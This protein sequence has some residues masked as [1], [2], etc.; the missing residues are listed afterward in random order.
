MDTRLPAKSILKQAPTK[1]KRTVSDEQKAQ[2]ERNRRN[3]GI[4]LHH[5]NKI[6]NRKD[7]EAQILNSIETLTDYPAGSSHTREEAADFVQKI[8]LFQ[9]SDF[10]SL[11]EERKSDSKCGYA[12]CPKAPRSLTLGAGGI[13]KLKGEGA[14]DYCSNDCL[15][16]ALYVKTQLSEVPAWEREAGQE[17]KVELYGDGASKAD[18][19]HSSTQNQLNGQELAMERG[20]Q[21]GSFRSGQV[22]LDN[23]MEKKNVSQQLPTSSRNNH[24]AHGSIEGYVPIRQTDPTR[25]AAMGEMIEVSGISNRSAALAGEEEE[26]WRALYE[27]L[28]SR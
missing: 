10:A 15:R 21:A 2:A 6:Q 5:A 17:V 7:I 28:P 23:I 20:E 24:Y 12:L 4:A 19:S 18:V 3:L 16:K 13:W 9:P 14:A 11:V 26:S 25:T 27:N 1:S 8:S 22:M